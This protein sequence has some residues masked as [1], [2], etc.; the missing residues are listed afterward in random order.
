VGPDYNLLISIE[1]ESQDVSLMEN[2]MQKRRILPVALAGP[3]FCTISR[4]TAWKEIRMYHL[5]FSPYRHLIAPIQD[6][7]E[8]QEQQIKYVG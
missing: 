3:L 6:I 8:P 4:V 7:T 2:T 5:L 1:P